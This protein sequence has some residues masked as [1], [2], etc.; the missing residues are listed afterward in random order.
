VHYSASYSRINP[1]LTAG[2]QMRSE[3]VTQLTDARK[4]PITMFIFVLPFVII[5]YAELFC[6]RQQ[7]NM[8][9]VLVSSCWFR[10]NK[11]NASVIIWPIKYYRIQYIQ[12]LPHCPAM[13]TFLAWRFSCFNSNQRCSGQQLEGETGFKIFRKWA[14][15]MNQ[16]RQA[17]LVHS[18]SFW[19]EWRT[20]FAN[21]S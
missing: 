14:D 15:E 19:R 3:I 5:V 17:F 6:D 21:L 1:R 8:S 10:I 4:R 12:D 2:Q 20:L 11:K 7:G 9:V 18:P 16:A 13:T